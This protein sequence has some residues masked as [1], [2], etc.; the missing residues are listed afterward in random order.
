MVATFTYCLLIF[1]CTT[2]TRSL[3][4]TISICKWS[5]SFWTLCMCWQ[6]FAKEAKDFFVIEDLSFLRTKIFFFSLIIYGWILPFDLCHMNYLSHERPLCLSLLK[7][8][9]CLSEWSTGLVHMG[10]SVTLINRIFPLYSDVSLLYYFRLPPSGFLFLV[11]PS[12]SLLSLVC[13]K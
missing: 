7:L 4:H 12:V 10:Y 13:W 3:I 9:L 5:L 2:S 1:K 11:C 6:W 8:L